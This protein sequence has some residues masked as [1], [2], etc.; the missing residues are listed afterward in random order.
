MYSNY[1]AIAIISFTL[2]KIN[3]Y[4]ILLMYTEKHLPRYKFNPKSYFAKHA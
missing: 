1:T 2:V 3:S 4:N